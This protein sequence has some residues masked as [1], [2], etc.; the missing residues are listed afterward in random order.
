MTENER[1][2]ELTAARGDLTRLENLAR[3][4]KVPHVSDEDLA[5]LNAL[6][7]VRARILRLEGYADLVRA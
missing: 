3:E 4:R 2:L 1:L 7:A 5:I 6:L